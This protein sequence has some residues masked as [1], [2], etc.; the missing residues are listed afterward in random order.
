M[1]DQY[2]ILSL[3]IPS[4]KALENNIDMYL[5]PSVNKLKELW[6]HNVDTND[7]SKFEQFCLHAT[8]LWTINNFSAYVN[9]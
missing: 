3:H 1:K 9:L 7:I 6:K 5:Q 4:L 8:L 2:L